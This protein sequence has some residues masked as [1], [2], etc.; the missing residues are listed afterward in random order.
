MAAF[1]KES[2]IEHVTQYDYNLFQDET[3]KRRF[4]NLELL[5][6]SALSADRMAQFN[7]I[8]SMMTS[9][10]GTGKICPFDNRNCDL[11]TE[12]L[13]L[14]PGIEAILADTPNRLEKHV[15]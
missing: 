10:Y 3:L 2:W 5:G 1:E 12:G 15:P 6:N 7:K 4:K 11:E 14:E 8:V 13:G 9:T